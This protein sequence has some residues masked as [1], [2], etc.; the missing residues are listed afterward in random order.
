MMY[1]NTTTKRLA[2]DYVGPID[3]LPQPSGQSEI[4]I[5]VRL[6]CTPH[7][8]IDEIGQR[9][10]PR[11]KAAADARRPV[12]HADVRPGSQEFQHGPADVRESVDRRRQRR[13]KCQ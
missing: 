1:E 10:K 12:E 11:S 4:K 2:D 8:I 13:N 5:G 9:T 6:S 7:A 3:D